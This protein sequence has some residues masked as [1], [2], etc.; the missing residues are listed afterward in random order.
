[1]WA[2]A[3]RREALQVTYPGR[4]YG[5]LLACGQAT[6]Q[7]RRMK[8]HDACHRASRIGKGSVK[9]VCV[10]LQEPQ[11]GVFQDRGKMGYALGFR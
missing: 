3:W 1:M 11:D 9:G 10:R 6:L 4:I 8:W 5:V 2:N 7:P